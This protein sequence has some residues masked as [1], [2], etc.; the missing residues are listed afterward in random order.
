MHPEPEYIR[1]GYRG[2]ERLKGKV[3]LITG[4]DSGIGRAIAVHFAREGADVAITYK[5]EDKDAVRTKALV[6]K[7]GRTCLL[8]EWDLRDSGCDEAIFNAVAQELG[9]LDIL[10]N[11]A[12]VQF[13]EEHIEDISMEHLRHTFEVNIMSMIRIT[14]AAVKMM[15]RPA[16][17]INTASITAYRGSDH[18]IDYASTKGAI[19]GF[20]RSLAKNLADDD[21]LVNAVAPGPIWTPL[22]PATFTAKEVEQF[23]KDT[24]LG[25]PG[26]P[27]EV[28][29]AYVFL[30]SAD[31]TYITGQT[32][33]INGGEVVG[34]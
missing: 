6:A 9:G 3:A 1:K 22:I 27:S 25:R 7:E 11:N 8:V 23:G 32:I 14:R 34:G 13:P 10:V 33:H 31:S 19:V 4:G 20:T 24:P 18:L 16:R 21:I 15:N 2:S 26:Q 28:A 30:A 12:A 29:P 5:E 17:I